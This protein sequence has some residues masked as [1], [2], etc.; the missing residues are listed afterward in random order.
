MTR[1]PSLRSKGK[2]VAHAIL[3]KRVAEFIRG[4]RYRGTLAHID[5]EK[6]LKKYRTQFARD[7]AGA[8]DS[9]I[10]LPMACRI[11]VPPDPQISDAFQH[12]GWKDPDMVEEFAGFLKAASARK[13]LWDV[14]ALFG[15]FSLAFTLDGKERRALAFEPNPA[16]RAKL[17]ECLKVNPA[18]KVE[19]FEFALGT[20]GETVEFERGFHF[21]AV[22]GLPE[23]PD[24]DHLAMIETLSVDE[25]IEKDFPAPD[26]IKIDVEGHEFEVL[27]GAKK[28]LHGRKPMLSIELHP[29]LLAHKGSSALAIAEFL[30]ESGYVFH[31]LHLKRVP[32]A[33][34]ARRDN[35]RIVAM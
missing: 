33:Y 31:D 1:D 27:R 16:S 12:F 13:V 14:G 2:K 5:Y 35:F 3:P 18:A 30:E 25:L 21:T 6:K 22:A 10:V 26:L 7:N 8:P 19:V 4:C 23:R 32:K 34:F 15:L 17:K 20:R 9:T 29:G 28:L 24:A 11:A